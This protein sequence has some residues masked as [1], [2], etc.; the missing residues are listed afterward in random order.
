MKKLRLFSVL[1]TLVFLVSGISAGSVFAADDAGVKTPNKIAAAQFNQKVK[2]ENASIET[3][4]YL[5]ANDVSALEDNSTVKTSKLDANAVKLEIANDS[6]FETVTYEDGTVEKSYSTIVVYAEPVYAETSASIVPTLSTSKLQVSNL[7]NNKSMNVQLLDTGSNDKTYSGLNVSLYVKI[8]YT[9]RTVD[10]DTVTHLD[11]LYGKVVSVG[12]TY[13]RNLSLEIVN[14]GLWKDS[15]SSYGSAPLEGQWYEY[16]VAAPS[17]GTLY[18]GA[19]GYSHYMTTGLDTGY[20]AGIVTVEYRHSSSQTS[21]SS[22]HTALQ[23]GSM[24]GIVPVG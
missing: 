9:N 24:S 3:A 10:G 1:L 7:S 14:N 12:V 11:N 20:V 2:H 8:T 22:D 16:G 21:W 6:P 18:G 19:N 13:Y 23:I 17:I 5:S 15:S 4:S